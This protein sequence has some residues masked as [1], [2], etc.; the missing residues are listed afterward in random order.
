[1]T[2]TGG[3]PTSVTVRV[4]PNE[5]EARSTLILVHFKLGEYKT[6]TTVSVNQEG[7]EDE[8]SQIVN[9]KWYLR[10]VKDSFWDAYTLD[11]KGNNI[12]SF[13][14]STDEALNGMTWTGTWEQNGQTI[15][16]KIV[17]MLEDGGSETVTFSC[18][19]INEDTLNVRS[20]I[21]EGGVLFKKIN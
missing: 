9:T 8:Q 18:Y 14:Y 12:F 13:N 15:V 2:K 17:V 7:E 4:K 10:V 5:G 19:F 6:F 11:F 21:E 1:M 16:G 20:P 3:S